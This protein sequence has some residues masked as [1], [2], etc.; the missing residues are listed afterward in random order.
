VAGGR[1]RIEM[2]TSSLPAAAREEIRVEGGDT[3]R[4]NKFDSDA[5]QSLLV[6]PFTD[7]FL[8][9]NLPGSVLAMTQPNARVWVL[10]GTHSKGTIAA[11]SLFSRRN[12]SGFH[13]YIRDATGQRDPLPYFEAVFEIPRTVDAR[14]VSFQSLECRHVSLLRSR[15]DEAASD[16][17]EWSILPHFRT[18]DGRR[19]IPLQVAHIDPVAGCNFDCPGC[20]E[21]TVRGRR[22]QL[23]FPFLTDILCTLKDCG[24]S[25]IG[26]YGGEPTEH[27]DFSRILNVAGHMGFDMVLVTNGSHLHEADLQAAIARNR[28]KLQARVSIDAATPETHAGVHGIPNDGVF[29]RIVHGVTDLVEQEVYVNISYLLRP[30]AEGHGGNVAE[31]M[32][33]C[34]FWQNRGARQFALR[35]M[36]RMGGGSPV[37]LSDEERE[38]VRQII[39]EFGDFVS[40]PD[41]FR[42]WLRDGDEVA[43]HQSKDYD[44]CHSAFYRMVI[45]PWQQEQHQ[46]EGRADTD[47]AW[48]SLCSYR[49][50]DPS[51]GVQLPDDLQTWLIETRPG[52]VQAFE[53]RKR[54][55][56][57]LCCRHTCNKHVADYLR[58]VG[59]S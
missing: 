47:K 58:N 39:P 29:D 16:E 27:P 32:D 56:D 26:F 24:C 31:V 12:L 28:E 38:V 55:K 18:E 19:G 21:E 34:A 30:S 14:H 59:V 23:S 45:S 3:F 33:S 11:V 17:M 41:W 36:T 50:Y 52:T 4:S 43:L 13:R 5:T 25:K 48:L 20:I 22:L 54:C 57:V 42:N 44:E 51:F 37:L 9:M 7:Y 1:V 6:G 15:K 8:V 35:P 46:S 10:C 49:R 53:P 2:P 40:T